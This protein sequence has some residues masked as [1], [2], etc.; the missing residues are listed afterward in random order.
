MDAVV[1]YESMFGNTRDIAIAIADGLASGFEV[2]CFEVGTAPH[3]FAHP[4]LLVV[5]GPTHAFSMSRTSTRDSARGETEEPLVS[6]MGIR[7]WL[8]EVE[9]HRGQNFATFDTK[10]PK[11]KLP[12]SAAASAAKR[13]KRL[14]GSSIAKP[15]TFWVTDMTGPLA[16][17][18]IERA[19]GWGRDLTRHPSLSG[20]DQ[21]KRA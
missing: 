4:D 15:E 10:V 5:G 2:R 6:S 20:A 8:E 16:D 19:R 18:E 14:H 1:V 9:V 11:P 21:R 3:V 13:L 17:G 7:D 12:G